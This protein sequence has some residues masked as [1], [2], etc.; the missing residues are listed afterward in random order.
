[1]RLLQKDKHM[2]ENKNNSQEKTQYKKL[3]AREQYD[4]LVHNFV[5]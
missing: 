1:M 3:Y 4:K 5:K 2:E